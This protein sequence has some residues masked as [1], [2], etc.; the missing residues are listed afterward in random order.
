M[1]ELPNQ[2]V[3]VALLGLSPAHRDLLPALFHDPGVNVCWVHAPDPEAP[4]ARLATLFAFPVSADPSE[5]ALAGIEVIVRPADGTSGWGGDVPEGILVVTD[6][7]LAGV[8]LGD[9]FAWER[10]LSAGD[11]QP[12]PTPIPTP[13]EPS[14]PPPDEGAL[15]EEKA[16]PKGRPIVV[17]AQPTRGDQQLPDEFP[18]W[19][20]DLLDPAKLGQW[21]CRRID[22][23]LDASRP[24]LLLL[25]SRRSFLGAFRTGG[26]RSSR[27]FRQSARLLAQQIEVRSDS[28]PSNAEPGGGHQTLDLSGAPAVLLERCGLGPHG[29]LGICLPLGRTEQVW[30][31]LPGL[32][33]GE[34]APLPP[35]IGSRARLVLAAERDG[36]KLLLK[37]QVLTN[38]ARRWRAMRQMWHRLSNGLGPE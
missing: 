21:L 38:Q 9:G 8:W 16:P 35:T 23:A 10:L 2:L 11:R 14:P 32:P 1:A 7:E 15:A 30:L 25:T 27:Q 6:R 13:L 28:M 24:S 34:G 12:T 31:L 18:T 26:I 5:G 29:A 36:L 19:L 22:Q 37:Q 33:G 4:L 17:G 20:P 3:Q